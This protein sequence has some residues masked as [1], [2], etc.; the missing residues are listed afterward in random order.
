MIFIMSNIT[1]IGI[2]LAKSVF[3][4]CGLNQARNKVFN[5]QVQRKDLFRD[6]PRY[7]NAPIAMKACGSSH[8]W[9]R[10]FAEHGLTVRL[11][12]SQHVK[13]VI[14]GNKNDAND[15]LP[16]AESA[17]RPDLHAGPT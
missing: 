1:T 10:T 13:A 16:I 8:H 17:L 4:V 9:A 5:K 2:N 14:R 15:A 11:I 12:P 7:P 6:V 3:Q